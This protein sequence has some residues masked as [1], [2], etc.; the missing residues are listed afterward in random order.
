MVVVVLAEL[1]LEL[2]DLL[3][4]DFDFFDF[5][6]DEFDCFIADERSEDGRE[7][8]LY[9]C[10]CTG[11]T[12]DEM[13]LSTLYYLNFLSLQVNVVEMVSPRVSDFP[14]CPDSIN[15][16]LRF[17]CFGAPS[18]ELVRLRF[19]RVLLTTLSSVP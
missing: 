19:L 12:T 15:S 18:Y 13:H 8:D 10:D 5:F 9:A 11:E 4:D 6:Y 17:D 16:A 7:K 14:D 3:C 2:L 1:R